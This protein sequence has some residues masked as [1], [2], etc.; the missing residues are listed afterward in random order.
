MTQNL[1]KLAQSSGP[2]ARI[3]LR[4]RMTE[5]PRNL[6]DIPQ[7]P[8]GGAFT[9]L[10]SSLSTD[11][12]EACRRYVSLHTKLVNF[13]NMKGVSDPR[14]AA[15]EVMDRA[16][17][18]ISEG[19]PVTNVTSYCLGIA[20]NVTKERLRK[21]RR[22]SSALLTFTVDLNEG[23]GE[24]IERI[25]QLLKPCFE[26]LTVEEQQ[27]LRAYCQALTGRA[28]AEHRRRLADEMKTTQR[29]LRIRITRLR[30]RLWECVRNRSKSI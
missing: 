14:S 10:L 20:R 29:A 3:S 2:L 1:A 25:N 17:R 21:E 22:E 6:S 8:G 18:R 16:G 15:D 24:E 28:R 27:V 12:E 23:L 4:P 9:R 26:Q 11:N 19:A 30:R 5:P 13:F 7:A